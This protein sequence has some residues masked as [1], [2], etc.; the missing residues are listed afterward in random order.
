MH[1]AISLACVSTGHRNTEDTENNSVHSVLQWLKK[2]GAINHEKLLFITHPAPRPKKQPKK[3]TDVFKFLED[4]KK[5][6]P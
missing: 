4:E 5:Q 1:Y 3:R 6:W 2:G